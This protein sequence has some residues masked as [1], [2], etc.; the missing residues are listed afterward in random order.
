M[1]LVIYNTL[2][3]TKELFVP[4]QA[5]QVKLYVCGP[6]VY[7]LLHIGNFRGAIFFNLVRNWLE[8]LDYQVTFV[9]N[10][11]DVDDKI[12]Q[13]ALEQNRDP[14]E[15]ADH[16]ILEFEKDFGALDLVPHSSNP[17]VTQFMG[18]IVDMITKLIENKHAYVVEGEVL[19]SIESFALYGCLS[20]KNIDEL[21]AGARVEIDTKKKNP[22]DFSLWKPAKP[23]EP[24]WPSPWG[25]GRPG[26]HIE[27]SAMACFLLGESIDI[28]GGGI[29][30]IFPH[31]ENEIAQSQGSTG[32]P[33]VKYWVHNNFINMGVEKMSKSLGNVRTA[34]SFL[35]QYNAEIL[36]FMLL[37]AHYR[38]ESVFSEAQIHSTIA[39]LARVYSA[40][41]RAENLCR[42]QG[43]NTSDV[44]SPS[45]SQSQ[46][47]S[48][49]CS[50][51]SPSVKERHNFETELNQ[52][53]LRIHAALNDDFNT[54]EMFA[55]IFEIV[56]SFNNSFKTYE[57]SQSAPAFGIAFSDWVRKYGKMLSL[58]Q[59]PA[60][61][62]LR[63]LDDMLLKRKQLDRQDIDKLVIQRQQA[64]WDQDFQLA[65]QIRG[66]L[67]AMGI[68]VQDGGDGVSTWEVQK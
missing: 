25:S 21:K 58:F 59:R 61:E 60:H 63:L 64:R 31:H 12:I 54:P 22:L 55:Q 9:Y 57:R 16:Y 51:P 41:A 42:Q 10:Y 6:T 30:L 5:G 35:E 36:K 67:T 1:S 3:R 53:S 27:C 50:P 62:F 2:S 29:D 56:R 37:S 26:W 28:H 34:R 46:S 23:G 32:R 43:R 4:I 33:F 39:G 45:P 24:S 20:H 18:P 65:D 47:Q 8:H 15:F 48:Q 66:Q 17:R 40:L 44:P 19:Y 52:A 68:A 14:L 7:D 13:R 11:T 49:S 38:T